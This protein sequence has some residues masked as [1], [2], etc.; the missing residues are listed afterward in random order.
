LPRIL[1]IDDEPDLVEAC[2]TALE[3]AGYAVSGVTQPEEAIDTARHERPDLVILDWVMP[4][5]DGGAILAELHADEATAATP[6]L[7]MSAL[8]DGAARARSADADGFL[9]KPFD[10]DQLLEQVA[11][12]VEDVVTSSSSAGQ[13]G[14]RHP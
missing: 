4:R 12:L 7:V 13:A 3:G 1:I 8:A 14:P 10:I 11:S 2:T 5:R 6:V 9:A